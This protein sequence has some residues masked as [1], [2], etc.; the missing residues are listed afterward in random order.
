MRLN[1]AWTRLSI[2]RKAVVWLSTVAFVIV[3]M[4]SIAAGA[5]VRTMAELTRLQENDT[6]CYAVQDALKT[7]RE[8]FENLVR[9]NSP[10]DL[11]LYHD[12]CAATVQAITASCWTV[13]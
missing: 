11:Q 8:A 6:R 2:R 12:A 10:T 5:R 13:S 9:T 4:M 3:A 7:E 1:G